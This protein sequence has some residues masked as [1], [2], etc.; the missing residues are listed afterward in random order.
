MDGR[1]RSASEA[2]R[3]PTT[4]RR[5]KR[6]GRGRKRGLVWLRIVLAGAFLILI[7]VAAAVAGTVFAVTRSLPNL[8]SFQPNNNAL[9]T[10]FYDA[11]GNQIGGLLTAENRILVKSRQIP[12][13]MKDA[14]VAIEDK[15]FYQHHGID[16]QGLARAIWEDIKAGST[17]QGA[18]TIEGQYIDNA[19][20]GQQHSFTR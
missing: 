13:I 4:R 6:N 9:T 8:N 20:L 16:F 7:C 5:H 3:R 11:T 18:S 2:E 10:L 19:Y 14:V 15:R 17:V 12:Q 1:E